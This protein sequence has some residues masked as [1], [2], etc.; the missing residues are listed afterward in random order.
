[1]ANLDSE[2]GENQLCDAC[3]DLEIKNLLT[4]EMFDDDRELGRR[5]YHDIR[6]KKCC[7]LCRLV[8]STLHRRVDVDLGQLMPST[9]VHYQVKR[10]GEF[11]SVDHPGSV[12]VNRLALSI[13]DATLADNP[14]YQTFIQLY[15]GDYTD[16]K[17]HLHDSIMRGRSISNA[18]DMGLV[19]MWLDSCQAQHDSKCCSREL[20][21][22]SG[23]SSFKLIDVRT[24][25]V[26]PARLPCQFVALSYVWGAQE[27]QQ[28]VLT[29]STYSRLT[30]QDGLSDTW[31]DVPSTIKDAMTL[32]ERLQVP[33]LWV[34]ALCIQQDNS[35]DLQ[36]VDK[37]DLIY[38]GAQFTIVCAAGANSWAGL[39]GVQGDS[40]NIPPARET[41]DNMVL[42][43][44]QTPFDLAIKG[45]KWNT[46]AWTFQESIIS[47]RR[48]IFTEHQVFYECN[49]AIWWEDTQLEVPFYTTSYTTWLHLVDE[50][51]YRK[52]TVT[53]SNHHGPEEYIIFKN[54]IG[55]V[56]E[57]TAREMTKISDWLRGFEGIM[58]AFKCLV[59]IEFFW[60]LPVDLFGPMLVFATPRHKLEARR[61]KFPSWSWTGWE[62]KLTKSE[63]RTSPYAI[64]SSI[65][66]T[67]QTGRVEEALIHRC[68]A[69]RH[70]NRLVLIPLSSQPSR[71]SS[72]TRK[73]L[74]FVLQHSCLTNYSTE[75]PLSLITDEEVQ[76]MLVV[77]ARSAHLT[78]VSPRANQEG[79]NQVML[80]SLEEESRCIAEIHLDHRWRDK[81]GETLEFIA[82]VRTEHWN[83]G[84]PDVIHTFVLDTDER[85]VSERIQ[86]CSFP[87]DVWKQ[88][89]TRRRRVYLI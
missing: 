43:V 7:P 33:F 16:K 56:N 26:V 18:I 12:F 84:E 47:K 14:L 15:S 39:P 83:Y 42:V 30:R 13:H 28:L 51:S 45:S 73:I 44:A 86:I 2:D 58:S 40:R 63:D 59:D 3:A 87:A 75:L 64:H 81:Q 67:R 41:V 70:E 61:E 89:N 27:V 48:L 53:V 54:Y 72:L 23:W 62:H 65:P 68:R 49:N 20:S 35:D 46:R 76:R 11:Q 9:Q 6:E 79:P 36:Q 8:M 88:V 25:H 5:D 21:A 52:K 4:Q 60:G 24:R 29:Q 34:D 55:L 74:S 50:W 38:G 10:F 31:K 37:M 78:V 82:L 66:S 80:H 69:L 32:C 1:M 57:Y 17:E 77:E 71:Y 85:G 22:E 19:K